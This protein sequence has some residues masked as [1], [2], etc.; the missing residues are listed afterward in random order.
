MRPFCNSTFLSG[1]FSICLIKTV[2]FPALQKSSHCKKKAVLQCRIL[3]ARKGIINAYDANAK[4]QTTTKYNVM[5]RLE[6]AKR[7]WQ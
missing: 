4:V 6:H 5:H 1:N 2:L 3:K 7:K